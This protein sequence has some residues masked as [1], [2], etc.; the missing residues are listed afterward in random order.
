MTNMSRLGSL[1]FH[2]AQS[3]WLTTTVFSVCFRLKIQDDWTRD[4]RHWCLGRTGLRDSA[5]LVRGRQRRHLRLQKRREDEG[6]HREDQASEPQRACHLYAGKIKRCRAVSDKLQWPIDLL[7]VVRS[8][9]SPLPLTSAVGPGRHGVDPQVRRRVPGDWEEA[10]R[11]HQQRGHGA[12]YEG[13]EAPV[14]QGQP[15]DHHGNKP[16]RWVVLRPVWPMISNLLPN[17]YSAQFEVTTASWVSFQNGKAKVPVNGT[18]LRHKKSH[19]FLCG[20]IFLLSPPEQ[21]QRPVCVSRRSVP[22]DKPAPGGPE[23]DGRRGGRRRAHH[24]RDQL[25]A[26]PGQHPQE[27]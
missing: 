3:N 5:L 2:H 22:A 14:H 25:A 16:F 18:H 9:L 24:Q 7:Y 12:G 17:H 19:F 1:N 4:H 15:R 26:R 8:T 21:K 6:G 23:E 27:N 11:A 10:A 13:Y 20:E